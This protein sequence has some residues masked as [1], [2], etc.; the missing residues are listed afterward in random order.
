MVGFLIQDNSGKWMVKWSDLHSFGHGTHWSYT[1]IS[2]KYN[3]I[4]FIEDGE[5]KCK[6]F[7]ENEKVEFEHSLIG[8]DS[9]TFIPFRYAELLFPEVEKF[10]KEEKIKE[11]VKNKGKLFS[12]DTVSRLRDGGNI[13]LISIPS[14]TTYYI[15]KDNWTLHSEYPITDDNIVTDEPTKVY[16]QDRLEKYKED[17]VFNLNQINTILSKFK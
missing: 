9:N 2:P 4:K 14:K 16:I 11:Y 7:K 10:E 13:I 17:C 1:E 12:F 6:P 5:I 15:H 8:Y 3:S